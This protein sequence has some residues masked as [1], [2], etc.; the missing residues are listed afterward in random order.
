MRDMF[1][2]RGKLEPLDNDRYPDLRWTD[3]SA[4]LRGRSG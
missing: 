2:G 1:G 4:K 3:V